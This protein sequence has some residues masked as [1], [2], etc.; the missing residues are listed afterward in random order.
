MAGEDDLLDDDDD[1]ELDEIDR[2]IGRMAAEIVTE[3]HFPDH[4]LVYIAPDEPQLVY[5]NADL[6]LVIETETLNEGDEDSDNAWVRELEDGSAYQ[7]GTKEFLSASIQ[8]WAE[9]EASA[10]LAS[11]LAAALAADRL[12][13]ILVTAIA[14]EEEITSISFSQYEI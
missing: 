9:E 7:R 14:S 13:Y 5:Q 2:E 12:T 10:D 1:G 4:Q 8:D 6:Y 11:R 3:Q